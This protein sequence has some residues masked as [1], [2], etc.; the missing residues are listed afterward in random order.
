[1]ASDTATARPRRR[2]AA[3]WWLRWLPGSSL[4]RLIVILNVLGLAILIA[5]ALVLNELRQGLVNARIDSLTTQGELMASIIDQAATVGEP[6]PQMDPANAGVVLQML[7]NPKTQRARLFDAA[8]RPVADSELLADRVEQ[9]ALPPARKRGDTPMSL[10]LGDPRGSAASDA[11]KA[12]RAEVAQALRGR[13]VA[14]LRRGENG[15]RVVSVS[16]PIQRVQAVLGVLTL[17]ANDVDAIIAR[18]RM[19][20]IPFYL[21]AIAVSLASSLLLTRMIAQPVRRLARA[22][23]EA[24]ATSSELRVVWLGFMQKWI[25]QTAAIIAAE[26]ARGGAPET[27]PAADL[28]TSLNQMN[29]RTMMA[30]LSAETPAVD[31]DRVVDTLTHIWVTSIYGESR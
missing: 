21:I 28:A 3:P 16:I 6:F 18:E 25:D 30:A 19:A 23:T 10:R 2:E 5:G 26:R 27:I 24:L 13:P 17:E 14:V 22:A 4:G 29:E 9:K 20:Q 11:D 15:D 8:G 12:L 31:E 7:A 1:M